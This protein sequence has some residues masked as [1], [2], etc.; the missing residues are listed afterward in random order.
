ML[1]RLSMCVLGILLLLCSAAAQGQEP[2][3]TAQEEPTPVPAEVKLA[4]GTVMR[5]YIVLET[6]SYIIIE[7]TILG[8]MQINRSRIQS[9]AYDV[10]LEEPP[11]ADGWRDDPDYNSLLLVP[12]A[13][14]LPQGDL[15]YR[16]F[17]LLF[18]NFGFG[19]TDFFNVS[20][21][22]A[23]PVTSELRI[24]SVGAKLRILSH[25]KSPVALAASVS[26]W[27]VDDESL[28]T[29][30]G[31]ATLGNRQRSLTAAVNY[32]FAGGDDEFFFLVGGDIQV[33][34]GFKLLAE[35]GNSESAISDEN[36]FKGIINIGFRVFWEKVSFTFA[37][38]RPL[39]EAGSFIAF[40]IAMFS[41][42]F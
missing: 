18:N 34:T 22:A 29:F 42:H 33:A 12:T 38:F 40:P 16:N 28:G 31:I 1:P 9:I 19:I 3:T 6:T 21:M 37:G 27:F 20:A 17:E 8:R 14:T 23:F 2:P 11:R 32:G 15:Y 36:D 7:T 25:A 35:Y 4:D 30:S 39:E 13:E 5:G 24:F 10:D 41:A 26:G